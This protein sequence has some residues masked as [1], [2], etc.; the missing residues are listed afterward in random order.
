MVAPAVLIALLLVVL[1]GLLY[2]LLA[3]KQPGI[4]WAY[5][6]AFVEAFGFG[7]GFTAYFVFL[8]QV[9]QRGRFT[10]THYAMGTGLG[11]VAARSRIRRLGA[12]ASV[13]EDWRT[14]YCGGSR[15]GDC[16]PRVRLR[17]RAASP[18]APPP[19]NGDRE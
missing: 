6:V 16:A 13:G 3:F 15:D 7:A 14:R 17:E 8:M 1:P 10:T 2:V 11:F 19:H 18:R 4:V 9:A 12:V 5:P